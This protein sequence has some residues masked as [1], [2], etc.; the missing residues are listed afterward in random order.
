M[1]N[2]CRP[3]CVGSSL[4]W[5]GCGTSSMQPLESFWRTF[6]YLLPFWWPRFKKMPLWLRL[7]PSS[8]AFSP[9]F[10]LLLVNSRRVTPVFSLSTAWWHRP[11]GTSCIVIASPS[12]A[13]RRAS[14]TPKPRMI[15]NGVVGREDVMDSRA[16]AHHE[17]SVLIGVDEHIRIAR[18]RP[19]ALSAVILG[20]FCVVGWIG[21]ELLQ[22]CGTVQ[23]LYIIPS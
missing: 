5:C 7:R 1:I 15:V 4:C 10:I 22:V 2:Y 21:D 13:F 18:L 8:Q 12:H 20:C 3:P 14:N 6:G 11:P 19:S 17:A 23:V 9:L 16:L